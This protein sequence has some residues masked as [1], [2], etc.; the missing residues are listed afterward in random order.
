MSKLIVTILSL[1]TFFHVQANDFGTLSDEVKLK[2][3]EERVQQLVADSAQI[4]KWLN[5]RSVAG[6]SAEDKYWADEFNRMMDDESE[7]DYL[8]ESLNL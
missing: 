5:G 7:V 6:M 2:E 8:E 1:M 3:Q 4:R